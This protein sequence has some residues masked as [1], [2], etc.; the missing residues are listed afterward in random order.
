MNLSEKIKAIRQENNLSQDEMANKIYVTRQAVSKWERDL[1]YPSIDVLRLISKEFKVSM[2]YLL[3]SN[4]QDKNLEYKPVGFKHYGYILL[5]SVSLLIIILVDIGLNILT[6]NS[7]IIPVIIYN[8]LIGIKGLQL[9]YM[10]FISIFPTSKVLIEYNDYD[11]RIKTIAGKREIKYNQ[12][13]SI[14]VKTHGYW[15]SGKVIIKT[16]D[17]NYIVYPLKDINQV[18]S[19]IEEVKLLNKY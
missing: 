17:R 4:D 13:I 16:L 18:K 5:Y 6:A 11:I 1:S 15:P 8:I 19:I 7:D 12:I 9:I 2:N 3:D 14:D 10:L